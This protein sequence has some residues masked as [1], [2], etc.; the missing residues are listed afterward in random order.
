MSR[1][2]WDVAKEHA[3]IRRHGV[4]STEAEEVL[5]GPLTVEERDIW[6]SGSEER[7][8]ITGWSPL[9]RVIVV[10]VSFS[11]PGPRIISARRATKRE[12]HAFE[13]RP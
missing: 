11:G 1:Y 2:D 9:G 12:R 6:H 8:R 5:E 13:D 7:L 3:N 10:I 4:S